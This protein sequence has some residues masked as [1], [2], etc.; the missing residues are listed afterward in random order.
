[1]A[2]RRIGEHGELAGRQ[3]GALLQ[4]AGVEE[5]GR[6][7]HHHAE[8]PQRQQR[9]KEAQ[10]PT[11][12]PTEPKAPSPNPS[13]AQ[14]ATRSPPRP[15]NRAPATASWAHGQHPPQLPT[16]MARRSTHRGRAGQWTRCGRPAPC[17]FTVSISPASVRAEDGPETEAVPAT[18]R[19]LSRQ[20]AGSGQAGGRIE[21]AVH[22]RRARR[23]RSRRRA[24]DHE[25]RRYR[26]GGGSE[27]AGLQRC[28]HRGAP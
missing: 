14:P 15:P 13:G 18:A 1:M 12:S 5:E 9:P 25:L 24:P 17:R 2:R 10:P 11:Q 19:V 27:G 20:G 7:Q 8:Q 3:P 21:P 26:E 4:H 16:V 28:P 23:D 22:R 6:S